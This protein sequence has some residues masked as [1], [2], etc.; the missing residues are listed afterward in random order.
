MADSPTAQ[1]GS[2]HFELDAQEGRPALLLEHP[3]ES[4]ADAITTA[5]ADGWLAAGAW[6]TTALKAATRKVLGT[7]PQWLDQVIADVLKAHP[8][9][10]RDRPREL[11]RFIA[12]LPSFHSPVPVPE[13]DEPNEKAEPAPVRIRVRT[14]VPTETVRAPWHTPRLDHAGELAE[15]LG[16]STVELEWFADPR[17]MNRRATDRR[18]RHYRYLWLNGRLI[19]SPK[20]RLHALQRQVLRKLL[21]PIPVHDAAHGFVAGRSAHTFAAPHAGQPMVIRFDITSFFAAVTAPRV[22]GLLR[23]AGFPE[24]V[25]YALTA[26]CTTRTPNDVLRAAPPQVPGRDYRFALLRTP[27]LPQGAPTSPRLANL[28]GFRLDRRLAGLARSYGAQYTRYADDLAFSGAFSRDGA[29]T[30]VDRVRQIAADEGF[31]LNEAKTR[32]RGAADRQLLAGLVVNS[33]PSAP[34]DE[35]DNLRALL[36]N[37]IHSGLDEQN[38]DGHPDFAAHVAGRIAWVGHGHPTRAAKLRALLDQA[39]AR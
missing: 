33:R 6:T 8:R 31:R 22:F 35:Y 27:H 1:D 11:A 18:L 30:L 12:R 26:L 9:A 13:A 7:R 24:P 15:W 28:C 2:A 25:A 32:I 36:H 3:A 23:S 10:P 37:A 16:L 4:E 38:R 19:E 29:A 39:L 20:Q 34:R 14:V 21:D 5:L 17:A